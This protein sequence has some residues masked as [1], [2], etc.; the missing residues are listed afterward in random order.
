MNPQNPYA[1]GRQPTPE[2]VKANMMFQ[3]Q[4]DETEVAI[5]LSMRQWLI[6]FKILTNTSFTYGDFDGIGKIVKKI[7]PTVDSI[8]LQAPGSNPSPNHV[9]EPTILGSKRKN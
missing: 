8:R 3:K 1:T 5:K 2:E 7:Q 4:L 9:V 6:L